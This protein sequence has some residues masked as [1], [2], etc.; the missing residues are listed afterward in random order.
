[1]KQNV[2]QNVTDD[3]LRDA[4]ASADWAIAYVRTSC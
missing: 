4:I 3:M 1:M 2:R